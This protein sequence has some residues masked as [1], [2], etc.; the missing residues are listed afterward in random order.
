[1]INVAYVCQHSFLSNYME[2]DSL[3]LDCGANRAEFSTWLNEY[4]GCSIQGFEPD[5]RLFSALPALS[6]CTFHNIALSHNTGSTRLNL[7][8]KLCSSLYYKESNS[9]DTTEVKCVTLQDFCSANNIEKINLL[10][11]DIEGAE[12]P[13]L[14]SIDESFLCTKIAQITVEFHDHLD[15]NAIFEIKKV[16]ERLRSL[17][18]LCFKFT[19]FTYNDVLFV[20]SRFITLTFFDLLSIK[21]LKYVRGISRIIKRLGHLR[22]PVQLKNGART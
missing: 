13:I 3:V 16:I 8:D 22:K 4:I 6:N 17:G 11:M 1:M 9:Q 15:S 19:F 7:G 21:A 5:P 12:M 18:F 20:N 2:H 14:A 10:K